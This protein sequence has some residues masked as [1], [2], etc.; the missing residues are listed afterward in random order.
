MSQYKISSFSI[1]RQ[2]I[3]KKLFVKYS[4]GNYSYERISI[5]NLVFNETCLVVAKFKDFLIYDDSTE[6]LR[7]FFTCKDLQL[8]LNKILIFYETYS[9]I[10]PNYLVIE[11]NKYLY[12]NIR[13]KQKMIDAI[14]QIKREEYEN[15]KLLK[16]KGDIFGKKI[17]ENNQ[18]FTQKI[19]EEIKTFQNNISLKN[20]DNSFDLNKEESDT[21]LINQN[22]LLNFKNSEKFQSSKIEEENTDNNWGTIINSF[23]TNETNGSLTT[24]I[25]ALNDSKIYAKGL[26]DIFRH[27]NDKKPIYKKETAAD[28]KNKINSINKNKMTKKAYT[29]NK[30]LQQQYFKK[31]KNKLIE[32][33]ENDKQNNLYKNAKYSINATNSSSILS[34]RIKNQITTSSISK[35]NKQN[36]ESD[37]NIIYTA[38]SINSNL[39]TNNNILY[40]KTS[41]K[42]DKF[43]LQ[44]HFFKI[45]NS[46]NIKKASSKKNTSEKKEKYKKSN[47]NEHITKKYM[48]CKQISHNSNTNTISKINENILNNN[49]K[50]LNLFTEN[51]NPNLITG[52]TKTN[53]KFV[54]QDKVYVNI[55]DI[56]KNNTEKEKEQNNINKNKKKFQTEQKLKT[57]KKNYLLL[58]KIKANNKHIDINDSNSNEN[59]NNIIFS[60]QKIENKIKY[61]YINKKLMTNQQKS[62]TGSIFCKNN[63]LKKKR[64][65]KTEEN[66]I[67]EKNNNKK[68][69]DVKKIEG[70]IKSLNNSKSDF[71]K[72]IFKGIYFSKL[73]NSNS[74]KNIS[75]NN[76]NKNYSSNNSKTNIFQKNKYSSSNF[77]S[78]NNS[79]KN[80]STK[81]KKQFKSVLIKN[82]VKAKISK[83]LSSQ[84]NILS[85]NI[86]N[87]MQKIIKNKLKNDFLKISKTKYGS[88][89]NINMKD[90]SKNSKS[91]NKMNLL[92]TPLYK[93]KKIDIY[94]K[95]N[96]SRKINSNF[97]IINDKSEVNNICASSF[98]IKVNR[99][100]RPLCNKNKKEKNINCNV[101]IM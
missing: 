31:K 26:P 59:K 101:N 91:K 69:F 3:Y 20:Y 62:K 87:H 50:E 35:Y 84:K 40:T 48:K 46:F 29:N 72:E 5:N 76:K 55:R 64:N 97:K 86:F 27:Y 38:A 52:D 83:N 54:L 43:R 12:R 44:K 98:Y 33:K 74:N 68:I 80:F 90:S 18:L 66:S 17:S 23:V 34:K 65:T 7:R 70:K 93:N 78:L 36:K 41:P 14:N 63:I 92:K 56:I 75:Q 100:N 32:S 21:L 49:K 61:Y 6:F 85:I 1:L 9:K 15:K 45:D 79:S 8:R 24:A 19:K 82:S 73:N 10:F 42:L 95:S 22:S 88:E 96:T 2:I 51:N 81:I 77:N 99:T 53:E 13:K 67:N 71:N 47:P 60:T 28:N 25:N 39:N 4:S 16:E 94:K 30:I 89:M 58:T 37:K 11:E 57:N